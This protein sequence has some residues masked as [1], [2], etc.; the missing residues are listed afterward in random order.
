M[1]ARA[2]SHFRARQT[3]VWYQPLTKSATAPDQT[4]PDL[5]LAEIHN[6]FCLAGYQQESWQRF[7]EEHRL[8]PHCVFY[9]EL[10][11][12][13]E[14]TVK[15]VL[16]FL[17]VDGE[18]TFIP[19]PGSLKQSDVLSEEWEARYRRLRAEAESTD[20]SVPMRAITS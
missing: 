9:E 4:V 16:G 5:D 12:T 2:I 14:S 20:S 19:P 17:G 6:L 18:H 1:V 13:Y 11:E 7:F 15:G 8:S 3:G 10:V